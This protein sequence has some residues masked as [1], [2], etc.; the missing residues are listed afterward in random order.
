MLLMSPQLL[1]SHEGKTSI[2]LNTDTET[3]CVCVCVCVCVGV[4]VCVCV[5]PLKYTFEPQC[6]KGL[7]QRR[8]QCERATE[9][10]ELC[11]CVCVRSKKCVCVC[12][13]ACAV[14][15]V[16]IL[17]YYSP[18]AAGFFS[19]KA[20]LWTLTYTQRT[21]TDTHISFVAA[22]DSLLIFHSNSC[23]LALILASRDPG[24]KGWQTLRGVCV[25][26]CVCVLQR[27]V[28]YPYVWHDNCFPCW[29]EWSVCLT[30]HDRTEA[31]THDRLTGH[32]TLKH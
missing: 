2:Q 6:F 15:R 16:D 20:S 4:C 11:V 25:C 21:H 28:Y 26:V 24:R 23:G 3:C 12:V 13:F 27:I 19:H 14:G 10:N 31:D 8:L 22:G 18:V 32:T 30:G 29:T 1:A 17:Q 7:F 5:D 9:A